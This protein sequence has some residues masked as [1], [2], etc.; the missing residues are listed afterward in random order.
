M[1]SCLHSSL[2]PPSVLITSLNFI[3]K[4]SSLN[5]QMI[6]E[7]KGV[8]T[9]LFMNL[10]LVIQKQKEKVTFSSF[11]TEWF[12]PLPLDLWLL[13]I[14]HKKV[15]IQPWI[16][17]LILWLTYLFLSPKFGNGVAFRAKQS[18]WFLPNCNILLILIVLLV[19]MPP[20]MQQPEVRKK[21]HM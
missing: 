3:R 7:N 8:I 6:I 9:C 20:A 16:V 10:M 5:F 17:N 13:S 21:I 14:F 1:C 2:F 4:I 11:V 18:D 15:G 12:L 19:E